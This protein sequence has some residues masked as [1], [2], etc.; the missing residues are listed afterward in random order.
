MRTTVNRKIVG[1]NPIRDYSRWIRLK[2]IPNDTMAEWSKAVDS[3]P[4][5][6]VCAGSNPASV[7]VVGSDFK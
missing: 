6:F 1:S 4:T 7:N 3:R 2:M 5:I